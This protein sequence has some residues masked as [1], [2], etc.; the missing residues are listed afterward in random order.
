MYSKA[1]LKVLSIDNVEPFHQ[2][3]M[4]M[5]KG[6]TIFLVYRPPSGGAETIS[7]L[8]NLVRTAGKDSMLIGDFNLPDIDWQAG[9]AK[10]RSREFLEAVEDCMMEQMVEFSTHIRGNCLDLIVTNIP[11]RV[12]DVTEAGRLGQSDHS[13]IRMTVSVSGG[14]EVKNIVRPDWRKADWGSMREELATVDWRTEMDGCKGE[15]AWTILREKV[16]TT[17]EK[18]V[19]NKR[20]RNNNRPAWMTGEI[21]RTIRRKKN[22]WKKAKHGDQ[23]EEYKAV[24]KKTRNLI[25][26][27]KRRFEKRLADEG[28]RNGGNKRQFFAYIKQRTKSRPSIGP[29]KDA[30]GKLIKEDKDMADTLNTFFSTMFTREDTTNIPEPMGMVYGRNIST[31]KITTKK[32][33]EKILKLRPEAAAGP[34]KIGP[35]LLQELIDQIASPL[36]TVFRKTLEDGSVPEDWKQANVTP[37]FKK[38]SKASPGN[39]RPVSL[40]SV[41]CK[42]LES[43]I[44]DDIV[45]HLE[46]NRLIRPSQHGFMKGKSCVSNL[47]SFM[48]RITASVDGGDPVDIVF[49]DFAKAFDKVPVERLLRKVWAHGIRGQLYTWI[50]AWLKNR[51]QRVVLNGEA[52]LWAAVL[53]GVPQGSVLGPLLFLIFI[54]D[55]DCEAESVETIL[56]FADDTKVAQTIRSSEDRDKLQ[57]ALDRL[58]AWTETWGMSFNVLKCKVMHVGYNNPHYEYTMGGSK[59]AETKEE[60]DLGVVMTS[61]LKPSVQCSKAARTAQ[62]VLGQLSRA[63]HFRDR[64][65]FVQLYKQY[66]RPHLE[67]SCQAWAPWSA[68]DIDILEKVQKRAIRMVSGLRSQEYEERLGELELTTLKERRH[69]ADMAMVH[70][71]LTGKDNVDPAEWFSLASGNGR[72]TR[73]AADPLNVKVTHGRLE[74]RKN[75]FSVRVTQQWNN[76]PSEIKKMRTVSGFKK[77]YAA[78]RKK[79]A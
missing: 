71:I 66:V 7:E 26:S 59:L 9:T 52:S 4:F 14:E 73:L 58:E 46:K 44:K 48:E 41:S 32:V 60:R 57:M 10:G 69:Q 6:V 50:E 3:C 53:S 12:S 29:L 20:L 33:R 79:N 23:L 13:I 19:P 1:G 27:A 67:F 49:L 39:Y 68:A 25:R 42:I 24:E 74:T 5:V 21:L 17:V 64:H 51:L 28:E 31:V 43:I 22:L 30:A 8:A 47:L 11:E 15:E 78:Y 40:T 55:L 45:Q 37:I 72:V 38:G 54:N 70:R 18:H 61:N 34:D 56:K 2:Y 76:I 63:F 36:A 35:G 62:A 16:R 65:V 75:F 77:S